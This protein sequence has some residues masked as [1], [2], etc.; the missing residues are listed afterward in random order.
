MPLDDIRRQI[1]A[2]IPKGRRARWSEER[3][4]LDETLQSFLRG[5]RPPA[6]DLLATLGW[7]RQT[8]YRRVE[9]CGCYACTKARVYA[10]PLGRGPFDPRMSRMFL[11]ETCGNKRC[12]HAADHNLICTNSNEPG[13]AGSLYEDAPI[14]AQIAKEVGE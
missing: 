9:P 4:L 7:E 8:F 3:G 5:S 13:Q 12:P 6:D 10:E 2:R 11:C 14:R 1:D